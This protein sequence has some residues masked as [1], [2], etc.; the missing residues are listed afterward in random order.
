MNIKQIKDLLS[1][2]AWLWPLLVAVVLRLYKL[3][4]SAIWHDEGYT[5]WLIKYNFAEIVERTARDVHPPFYYLIS[6]IWVTLFGNSVFSIR[7][8]SLLFS[9]GI[10]Y[11]IYHIIKEI[12]SEKAAFWASMLVALSPFMVRFGQEARM[13][14][15]VAFFTTLATYFFVKYL[16]GKDTKWLW[17]YVPAM[18]AAMYT[19]YYSF[20][21]IISHWIILSLYTP[22]FWSLSWSKSWRKIGVLDLRWW[23]A[24]IG[25]FVAYLPWFPVAYR[26]VTRVSGSY[27]IKPEWI[28]ERTI[29]NNVFQFITYTHFDKVYY[30]SL[31]GQ[32]LYWLLIIAL[33]GSGYWLVKNKKNTS[34]V[35]SIYIFGLLPMILVF[36][37]SKLR[38]PVYQDRYFPFSAVA[39]FALW[40]IFISEVRSKYLKYGLVTIAIATLLTG[41]YIMHLDANHKMNDLKEPLDNFFTE[42]DLVTSGELYTFLDSSYYL[43]YGKVRLLSDGVDGYGESSLFYDQQDKYSITYKAAQD[44]YNHI[45]VV[46]KTGDKDYYSQKNWSPETWNKLTVFEEEGKSNGLKL[47]LYKKR[48]CNTC[49]NDASLIK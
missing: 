6:K 8:F 32:A 2:K 28:T 22:G 49:K 21:V 20:F 27:W 16:K 1:T 47:V 15:V 33:L 44:N 5:M 17:Y 11:L 34:K 40:G 24:N 45:W 31:F 38:T 48:D 18:I 13:Y 19:Q 4:A 36:T 39:L 25:L 43:G 14:G 9:V 37:L 42:G 10:V 30:S 7:F 35:A 26:Q 46:G 3:T 41:N 29:P 23:A 12:W